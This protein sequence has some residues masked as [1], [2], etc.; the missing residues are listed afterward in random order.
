[1]PPNKKTREG[2]CALDRYRIRVCVSGT[3]GVPSSQDI[4]GSESQRVNVLCARRE[5][6]CVCVRACVCVCVC[7]FSPWYWFSESVRKTVPFSVPQ[8]ERVCESACAPL[9]VQGKYF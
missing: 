2:G 5:K 9:N 6:M 4:C 3:G 8:S 1:M 7:V